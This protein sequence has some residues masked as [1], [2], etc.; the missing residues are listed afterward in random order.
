MDKKIRGVKR[1]SAAVS[2]PGDKSIAHRAVMLSGISRGPSQITNFPASQ[3]CLSTVSCMQSLGVRIDRLDETTLRVHGEGLR[4]LQQPPE[5]L[6]ASNSGTTMR[7]LSGLLAGQDF[8]VTLTGDESLRRRP[9]RRI[10]EP[11]R[12]MGA[13]ISGKAGDRFAPLHIRGGRLKPI[14]YTLPVASAQLKSAILLA[15]LYADGRTTVRSPVPCRDHTE[16][17]LAYRGAELTV[18]DKT[19]T[20]RGEGELPARDFVVPGD[21]SS[22]AYFLTAAV[23]VSGSNLTIEGVGVNPTRGGLLEILGTMGADIFLSNERL[24]GNEPVADLS[25]RSGELSAIE[26][27][28][29]IVPSL[30]DELPVLAVAATQARGMT[31]VR[32]AA[33]L[34]VKESDRIA[35]MATELQKMG[36]TIETTEDGWIIEGSAC[37]HGATVDSQGDHRIAM[38]LAVAAL[39]AEG[40]SCVRNAEAVEVSFPGFWELFKDVCPFS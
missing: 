5:P 22:A 20:I 6:D 11:L 28:G 9:M 10:I 35:A 12:A 27:F 21:L 1:I 14:D 8:E 30:I 2:L 31:I 17:M 13:E 16:R 33:E 37:L 15:G 34:R 24:V 32:D 25:V 39:V 38:A 29:P 19:V 3:D 7:L 26:V 4:G 23:L 18:S 40:E 36:A